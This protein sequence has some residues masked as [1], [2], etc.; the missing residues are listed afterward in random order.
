MVTIKADIYFKEKR[1]GRL[2]IEEGKLKKNECYAEWYDHPCSRSKNAFD[3]LDI[4]SERVIPPCRCDEWLLNKH[5][6]KEYNTWD[7]FRITNGFNGAD[8]IW[9]KFDD[10]KEDLEYKDI[11]L[12]WRN[13][14][15]QTK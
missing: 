11:I 15:L 13:E 7:I 4:L 5:G 3:V 10:D 1:V 8:S 9:F 6:L 14:K 2:E 12:R